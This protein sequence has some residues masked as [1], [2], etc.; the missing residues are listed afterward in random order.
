METI[1]VVTDNLNG[2]IYTNV[3]NELQ[4]KNLPIQKASFQDEKIPKYMKEAKLIIAVP[5]D[6]FEAHSIFFTG[7]KKKYSECMKELVIYGSEKNIADIKS[8]LSEEKIVASL[9]RPMESEELMEQILQVLD[10][11]RMHSVK[12]HILVVDDSGPMLRTIMGWLEGKY[13]VSL[14][15]AAANAMAMLNKE[16]PD[17]ILLDYEMPIFSGPQFLK[18]I[19]ENERFKNIPVI[20]LTSKSDSDDVKAVLDL[21]PQGYILKTTSGDTLMEKLEEFFRTEKE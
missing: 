20:F 14:A 2:F 8:V 9:V 15:N 18:S 10:K 4:M 6:E 3:C 7:F 19:R 1:L 13:R 21:K 5:S 11:I 17:L 12:K 16:I